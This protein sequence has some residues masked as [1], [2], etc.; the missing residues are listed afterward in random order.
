MKEQVVALLDII[1]EDCDTDCQQ[2]IKDF[3]KAHGFENVQVSV[4]DMFDSLGW[5]V[6]SVSVAWIENGK[7][8]LAVG[9]VEIG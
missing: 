5:D 1:N 4:D 2:R 8:E 6:Y 7:V 3:M 9:C